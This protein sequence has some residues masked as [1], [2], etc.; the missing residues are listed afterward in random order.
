MAHLFL[1]QASSDAIQAYLHERPANGQDALWLNVNGQPLTAD[2][3][4]QLVARLT[5]RA[6]IRG[7]HNLHAFRHRAAQAWLDSSINAEIVSQALWHANV[8]ITLLIN[9]NQDE[10]RV[11]SAIRQAETLPFEDPH[12]FDDADI[13]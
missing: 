7:R 6:G 3:I 12:G 10:R 2:G 4:R 9:G 5:R 1:G 8:N 13:S 11:R